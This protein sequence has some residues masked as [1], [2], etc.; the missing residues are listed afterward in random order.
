[1]HVLLLFSIILTAVSSYF[2]TL[3]FENKKIYTAICYFSGILFAQVVFIYQILSLFS[4][5]KPVNVICGNVIFFIISSVLFVKSKIKPDFKE[6]FLFFDSGKFFSNTREGRLA[7]MEGTFTLLKD[8]PY[9]AITLSAE[10]F[11]FGFADVKEGLSKI[12]YPVIISNLTSFDGSAISKIKKQLVFDYKGIKIGVLGVLSK[13]DFD[14]LPRTI[15]LKATSEIETLKPM[16]AKMQEE[17]AK[18]AKKAEKL[19]AKTA[20]K[21]EKNADVKAEDING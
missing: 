8:I 10:D 12:K 1:M 4:A 2:L 18:A 13:A 17:L 3:L 15:G 5:I 16:I 7:K 19:A 11:I 20:T 21:T 9:K 6:D 14:K